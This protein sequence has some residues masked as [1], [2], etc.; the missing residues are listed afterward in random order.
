[1]APQKRSSVRSVRSTYEAHAQAAA[2]KKAAGKSN[3]GE[4]LDAL[5]KH[6]QETF[7]RLTS[8]DEM[9]H[10]D[11]VV[12]DMLGCAGPD[13]HAEIA[14]AS[15][16]SCCDP[17]LRSSASPR[18]PRPPSKAAS[19]PRRKNNYADAYRYM[20]RIR[21]ITDV[22]MRR[23]RPRAVEQGV[24]PRPEFDPMASTLGSTRGVPEKAPS[25]LRM[26][27]APAKGKSRRDARAGTR[28][29]HPDRVLASVCRHPAVPNLEKKLSFTVHTY[30]AISAGARASG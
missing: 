28:W 30:P 8:D 21:S 4:A 15:I 26:Q 9:V 1:M 6:Q 19:L 10:F 12:Q 7:D 14:V 13:S 3:F 17:A 22:V 29:H 11:I 24:E 20:E 25:A 23:I 5:A 2:M 27:T 16:T 18:S